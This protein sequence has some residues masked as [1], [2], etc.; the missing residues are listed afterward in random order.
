MPY[1]DGKAIVDSYGINA[2][3]RDGISLEIGGTN[4]V[5]DEFSWNEIVHFIAYWADQCKVPWTTF[6]MNPATGISFLIWHQE[7]TI[8]TGKKCPF[9]YLMDNTNRLIADV[10]AF[11]RKYQEGVVAGPVTNPLPQAPVEVKQWTSPSPVR[12]LAM[13]NPDDAPFF[14]TVNGVDFEAIFDEVECLIQTPQQRYAIDGPVS[15]VNK[16][17]GPDPE[18]GQPHHGEL[19]VHERQG[20]RVP[21]PREPRTGPAEGRRC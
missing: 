15:E 6:P 4:E 19:Q 1:G 21:V 13:L 12:E 2:V 20:D 8:G 14:T 17:I 3:N 16:V 18:A 7:F 11:M 9:Q 5:I 10:A